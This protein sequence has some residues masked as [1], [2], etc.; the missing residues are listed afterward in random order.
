[1]PGSLIPAAQYIRMSTEHQ[2]YSLENQQAAI[3]AYALDHGFKVDRTYAD[4]GRSGLTLKGRQGLQHLLCDT[5]QPR[6][7]FSAILVLDVSRWGRF[8]DTDQSAHYEFICRQAG[9]AVHYC[10]E[11]FDNDGSMVATIMKHLKRVMAA[12]FSRELSAKVSRAKLQQAR[13]GFRQGGPIAFG[14]RR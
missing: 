12:E 14:F 4:P 2:R 7:D 5:L 3:A 10:D 13:L 8:Q 1:M 11:P 6:P 9:V